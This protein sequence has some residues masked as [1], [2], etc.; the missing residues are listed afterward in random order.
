MTNVYISLACLIQPASLNGE[1]ICFIFFYLIGYVITH[2]PDDQLQ[3][4]HRY[5]EQHVNSGQ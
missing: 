3:R 2:Q 1:I 5:T 4:Q